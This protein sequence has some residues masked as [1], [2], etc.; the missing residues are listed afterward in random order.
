MKN[1]VLTLLLTFIIALPVVS[2]GIAHPWQGKTVAYLGD[3]ITDPRNKA[4]QKKYWA[5]LQE[6]LGMTPYVYAV[7]GRQWNDVP[8]QADLLRTE[9]GD[10]FDAILIFMGTNDSSYHRPRGT[11]LL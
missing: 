5:W 10:D 4:A 6:W 8:R 11:A 1:R 9:H 7:S 2:Q 3:S